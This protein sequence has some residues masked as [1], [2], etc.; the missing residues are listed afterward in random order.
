MRTI[1]KAIPLSLLLATAACEKGPSPEKIAAGQ[2][3][4]SACA[5]G[6]SDRKIAGVLPTQAPDLTSPRLVSFAPAATPEGKPTFTVTGNFIT[7]GTD[8]TKDGD[9]YYKLDA[10]L[11]FKS[12]STDAEGKTTPSSVTFSGS[13]NTAMSKDGKQQRGGRNNPMYSE[14]VP[15]QGNFRGINT[16]KIMTDLQ[17]CGDQ[18]NAAVFAPEHS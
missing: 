10:N 13:R 15:S 9:L 7:D 6:D 3:A 4:M 8:K 18:A 17:A 11:T 2:T 5:L 12:A 1:T 16:S 14:T